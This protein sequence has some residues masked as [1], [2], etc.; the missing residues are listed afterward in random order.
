[1]AVDIERLI[2]RAAKRAGVDRALFRSLI[3]NGE[4]SWK[5]W[6]TSPAG[7]RGPSQLMP[8]TAAGLERKYGID[9]RDFFGN[10]LGGA[11]YLKEQL[12]AFKGNRTKAVAAY[13]AGPGNVQKYGGVPPFSETQKYVKNVLGGLTQTSTLPG[14]RAGTTPRRDLPGALS[15]PRPSLG[16]STQIGLP[17]TMREINPEP[18]IPGMPS[19]DV[20]GTITANLGA[21]ATGGKA[22]SSLDDLIA[23]QGAWRQQLQDAWAAAPPPQ[24]GAERVSLQIDPGVTRRS[25]RTRGGTRIVN[26][27]QVPDVALRA[28]ALAREYL[29]TPYS[30]GGGG[31]GGPS[32]GFGRGAAT[33]GFDCSSLLQFVWAKQGVS[34][35][36]VTYDQ[37]KAGV[38]VP[39]R[40]L[41]PGDAVF[42]RPGQ[43]G[44]EHV[45]MYIGNGMFIQ[46]PK[47][48]DVVKISRLDSRS[49]YMGARRY[50]R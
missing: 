12:D 42:F 50:G 39:K 41:R 19:P 29:G 30:W 28:V 22:S 20:V 36:R 10:L 45:G 2:T 17:T 24:P 18:P 3:M 16:Q 38:A 40:A 9:T 46:A 15:P 37:W 6:Q 31:P 49:D 32:R 34:I 7:A 33:V 47:T 26:N 13:N 27:G 8:G 48:G 43:R 35:P 44:P 23:S 11:Y 25:V 14:A 5:G 4:R 21:I 1:M